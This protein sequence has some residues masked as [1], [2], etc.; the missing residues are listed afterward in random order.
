VHHVF[1]A[2]AS[3]GGTSVS[4]PTWAGILNTA[5]S[6]AAS[7]QAELIQLYSD[8]QSNFNGIKVANCGPYMSIFAGGSWDFCSGRGSPNG[9]N[10]K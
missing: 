6:F 9:Y 10:G 2:T 8:P 1:G 7:S 4:S 5:G 3:V